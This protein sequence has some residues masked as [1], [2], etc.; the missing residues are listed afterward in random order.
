MKRWI[1]P[2]ALV[3]VI[4]AV[5]V[6]FVLQAD[7]KRTSVAPAPTLPT[8]GL[9]PETTATPTPSAT[10]TPECEGPDE[11]VNLDGRNKN[12][13]LPNCGNKP[14]TAEQ[15]KKSGLGLGCGG[16]Y[17]AIL[18]KTNTGDTKVS[19]CGTDASG[20]KFRVV[21]KE[22]GQEVQDLPGDYVWERDA[23]VGKG[24][25]VKYEIRGYDGSVHITRNG[26]TVVQETDD[27]MSL[28]NEHDDG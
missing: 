15:Q 8:L 5:V 14:V 22:R 6:F 26:T 2:V 25:G 10:P 9:P 11:P 20:L 21:V 19:V 24:S 3:A 4:G 28:E 12:S 18:F 1:I 16:S 23:F 17:P 13:L 7:E 27:W